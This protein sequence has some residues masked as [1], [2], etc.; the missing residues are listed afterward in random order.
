MMTQKAISD[1]TLYTNNLSPVLYHSLGVLPSE[2]KKITNEGGGV[3]GNYG[4]G[5]IRTHEP[6]A[7]LP[8]FKTGAIGHSATLP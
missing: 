3:R 4:R 8:V 2:L 1:K 7:G 6:I 5:R